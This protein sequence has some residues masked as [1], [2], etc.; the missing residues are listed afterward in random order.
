LR[1]AFLSRMIEIRV[2]IASGQADRAS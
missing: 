1:L 2:L